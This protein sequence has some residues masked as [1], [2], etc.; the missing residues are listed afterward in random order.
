MRINEFGIRIDSLELLL[1]MLNDTYMPNNRIDSYIYSE[2]KEWIH[3]FGNPEINYIYFGSEFCG[4]RIPSIS[5]WE[6][7]ALFCVQ[8]GKTLVMVMP[9][10]DIRSEETAIHIIRAITEQY[11]SVDIE[12]E[13][14]DF[15]LLERLTQSKM[16]SNTT[17]RLGRVLDKTFHDSRLSD[18]ESASIFGGSRI[19]WSEDT[20]LLSTMTRQVL[21]RYTVSGIDM[22][23]PT[24]ISMLKTKER[25][26]CFSIGL[27]VPYSY[28]TTGG[29]CQMH[30]ID[31]PT[32]H[33]FDI[34]NQE[35]TQFCRQYYES[36]KTRS[37]NQIATNNVGRFEITE[38]SS[39]RV[40]NTIF[41]LRNASPMMLIDAKCIDRVI[42]E[43]KLTI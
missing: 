31:I 4:N 22:D 15:G 41:Y 13:V 3:Y 43:P 1:S 7:V 30:N 33:K 6:N 24:I 23:I 42:F 36:L 2:V 37:K 21:Y 11:D 8:H 28:C 34:R 39:Y 5:E 17:I 35:C 20:Q 16:Q 29:L 18:Q 9:P 14:N 38:M 27:F 25:D 40:G 19:K 12:V 26:D 10:T 32:E